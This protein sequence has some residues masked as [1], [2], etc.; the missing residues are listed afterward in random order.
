MDYLRK[1]LSARFIKFSVDVGCDV[2]Y[3]RHTAMRHISWARGGGRT[4]THPSGMLFANE[5]EERAKM[6]RNARIKRRKNSIVKLNNT[7]L[8]LFHISV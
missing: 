2:P 7:F 5:Q 1:Q 3:A 6:E 4:Q 8:L